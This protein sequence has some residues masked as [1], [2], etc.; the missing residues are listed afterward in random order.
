MFFEY[1]RLVGVLKRIVRRICFRSEKLLWARPLSSMIIPVRSS[2][3]PQIKRFTE[4]TPEFRRVYQQ[5]T[6]DVGFAGR[7]VQG[8]SCDVAFVDGIP[9]GFV[10]LS[11]VDAEIGSLN[12][13]LRL[14]EGD[15]YVMEVYVRPTL[16]GKGLAP[17]MTERLYPELCED[18]Y[19]RIVALTDLGNRPV[20]RLLEKRGYHRHH[21]L[22]LWRLAPFE[23]LTERACH[24][25][26]GTLSIER[27]SKGF[28]P[29][30]RPRWVLSTAGSGCCRNVGAPCVDETRRGRKDVD[31]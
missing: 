26:A 11:R 5:F 28:L 18:G 31:R 10:W 16:R 8:V 21:R 12:A 13:T 6:N 29:L 9:A 17:I 3:S 22:F 14:G 25:E 15:A 4:A 23:R 19:R 2:P 27:A 30:R 20:F 24:P 7:F 1:Q